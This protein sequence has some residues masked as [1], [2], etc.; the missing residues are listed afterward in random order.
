MIRLENLSLCQGAFSMGIDHLALDNGEFLVILGPTGS[1][2][3]VLLETV[4]GLRRPDAGRIWFGDREVTSEVPER[5]RVGFVYQDYA[6]FPHLTVSG[7]IGFGLRSRK[8]RVGDEVEGR[9]ASGPERVR[10]LADL[11][12]IGQL[13]DRYPEGLSGGEKQRVALA[14]ALAI[15]PEILLLDEPLSALDRQTREGLRTLLKR[16]QRELGATVMHVT[17]DL[18]EALALADRLAVLIDGGIRQ[19]G[20]PGDVVRYPADAQVARLFGLADVLPAWTAQDEQGGLLVALS[21]GGNELAAVL[22]PQG[23]PDGPACAVIRAE[24][25]ELTKDGA[26][27]SGLSRPEGTAPSN[28]LE[29]EV[30]DIRLQSIYATV[31]V[32][33]PPV[34]AVH[35]LL[36]ELFRLELQVGAR[37]KLYVPPASIHVCAAG[38]A[39][40]S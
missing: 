36:P 30:R 8:S 37:V 23:R 28:L 12:G 26:V 3:T 15:E 7:N 32:E 25:I 17:H 27:P 38:P 16:L 20:P 22:P 21:E 10:R 11:L 2:K 9:A 39:G 6:L 34:L 24:E 14:R 29:G 5:R 1:G 40:R 13:L 19:T 4:A 35:L 33:L 18:E 31:D